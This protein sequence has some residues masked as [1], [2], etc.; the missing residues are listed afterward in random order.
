MKIKKILFPT[1]FSRCA[2]QAIAHAVFLAEKYDAEIHILHVVTI[3]ED[4]PRLVRDEIKE[5]EEMIRKLEDLAEKELNKLI[6]SQQNTDIKLVKIQRRGI[7]VAPAILDYSSEN[8][9]DLIVMGTHG[10][11]GLGHLFLGSAAEEVVRMARCPVFT[12]RELKEPKPVMAVNKIL[13]PVDFSN[14]SK[15]ALSYAS[16]IAQSYKAN[17]QVLHVIE[18]TINPA[19][20][21][22]GKSSIFDLIPGIKTDCNERIVKMVSETVSDKIK[23]EVHVISGSAANNIIKFAKENSTDLIVI[24][25]HGL[26]GL[27]HMLLGSVTE[28]VVRMAHCPVFTVKTFGKSLI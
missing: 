23:S 4:Q 24:A 8:N 25:T 16:K 22:S 26:T 1:D 17:L 10:R 3:F 19:F 9:I 18:E 27:E 7:S 11:R 6:S 14:Y 15:V 20:S 13:V 12:I 5:T 28:K 21:L 2:D